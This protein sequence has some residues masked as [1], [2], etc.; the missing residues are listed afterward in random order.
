MNNPFLEKFEPDLKDDIEELKFKKSVR[1]NVADL[2]IGMMMQCS[3]EDQKVD[4]IIF[5]E[6]RRHEDLV[7]N[8]VENLLINENEHSAKVKAK[9]NDFLELL[10]RINDELEQFDSKVS[11]SK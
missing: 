4:L 10:K 8:H 11:V 3:D 5:K 7:H 9:K 2:M 1:D 6:K